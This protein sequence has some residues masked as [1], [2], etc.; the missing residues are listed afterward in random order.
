MIYSDF[1]DDDELKTYTQAINSRAKGYG[2]A[3]RILIASL[4]DRIYA[5]GGQC[6]WCAVS[7]VRQPFEVDHI[8][9]LGRGGSNTPDNLS[10]AC[11]DCNRAKAGK[12]PARFAQETYART[13][14]MTD[15]LRH[16]LDTY[17]VQAV[18]QQSLFDEPTDT[19]TIAPSNDEAADDPPP[20]VWGK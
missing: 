13:G 18:V 12:H 6:E 7:L 1:L 8:T 16:V 10:V 5:S 15:L 14:I 3:G 9:S 4:R 20:Y 19:P 2:V 11:P 17:G